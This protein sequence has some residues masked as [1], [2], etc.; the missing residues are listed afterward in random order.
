MVD[1]NPSNIYGTVIAIIGATNNFP[2]ISD[3]QG[4]VALPP[5]IARVSIAVAGA[6]VVKKDVWI[7]FEDFLS[8][9]EV[10]FLT[11]EE[12]TSP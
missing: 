9:Y 6:R 4:N 10:R 7:T 11:A 3:S 1:A 5:I 8:V 2:F 12:K